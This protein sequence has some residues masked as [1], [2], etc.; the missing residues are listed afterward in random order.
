MA[1]VDDDL[2]AGCAIGFF[3]GLVE[4][5][6]DFLIALPFAETHVV[7]L[8][9]VDWRRTVSTLSSRLDFNL[10]ATTSL[11]PPS[12]SALRF[13]PVTDEIDACLF[14]LF[15]S[16]DDLKIDGFATY[17]QKS[18]TVDQ[19]VIVKDIKYVDGKVAMK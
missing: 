19:T 9:R 2:V 7:P 17:V 3:T 1:E 4:L 16:A 11:P 8:N 13:A 12:A 5:V 18:A 6:A 15:C 10:D 14:S